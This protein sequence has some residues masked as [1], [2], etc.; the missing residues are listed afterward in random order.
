[1]KASEKIIKTIKIFS[2]DL[3]SVSKS[4]AKVIREVILNV[5]VNEKPLANIACAG[6]HLEELVTG[7]LRSEKIIFRKEEIKEIEIS[8]NTVNVILKKNKSLPETSVKNIASSGARGRTDFASLTPLNFPAGIKITTEIALKLM[9]DL[10]NGSMIHNQTGGTHCSALALRGHITALRED[11]GRHN[12]IDML[13]GYAV[14]KK[15]NPLEAIIL[16]T[17]RISSEIIYK[18]W[19]MGIP[20]IISHSAPTANAVTLARKANMAL[21]GYVRKDKMNIYSQERRVII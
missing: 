20:V 19:N 7:F 5:R 8:K 3:S 12:T 13:A 2:G 16:T 6:L 17:G 4:S 18:V 1:M 21:I 15:I 11:I 9:D 14:L 10:L